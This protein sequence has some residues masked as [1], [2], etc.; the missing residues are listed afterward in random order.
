[1]TDRLAAAVQ[2]DEGA[3]ALAAVD[4]IEISHGTGTLHIIDGEP[5]SG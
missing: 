3:E 4:G 2:T 1:M 5:E